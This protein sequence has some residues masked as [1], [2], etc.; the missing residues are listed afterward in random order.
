MHPEVGEFVAGG[1]RLGHLVLVVREAQVQSPAVDV[2]ARTKVLGDHR[3]AFKVPSGT[4]RTPRRRP[5]RGLRFAF[6]VALPQCEVAGI[7]LPADELGFDVGGA[8]HVVD[9]LPRQGAVLAPRAHVEVDIA[10]VVRRGVGVA[11]VDEALDERVHFRD[12]SGG[13]RLV[14]G[15]LDAEGFVGVL[16]FLLV[17]VG[18]GPPFFVLPCGGFGVPVR[19][20]RLGGLGQDLVVDVGD[21]AHHGDTKATEF[22]PTGQLVE[23]DRGPHVAHVGHSLDGGPAVVHAGLAVFEGNE[24]A[25]FGGSGVIK[26]QGH[27]SR[28]ADDAA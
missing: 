21:V 9:V 17:A 27:R 13:P 8:L 24:V 19:A 23:G 11:P 6:L 2:E 1:L 28:L 5:A 3:G 10:R 4:A 26:A 16:E 25:D 12:V 14:G 18:Q 22:E 15:A 20:E 7:A